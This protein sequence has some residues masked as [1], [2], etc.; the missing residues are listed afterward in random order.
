MRVL[1]TF[2]YPHPSS[3]VSNLPLMSVFTIVSGIELLPKYEKQF[4]VDF[5][6]TMFTLQIDTNH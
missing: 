2:E 6:T 5:N 1:A 3:G 4:L